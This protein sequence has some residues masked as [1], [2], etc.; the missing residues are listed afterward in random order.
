MVIVDD[1]DDINRRGMASLLAE[2]AAIDVAASLTHAEALDRP[3][4]WDDVDLV[5]VDAAD[6]RNRV[7]HFPG[8]AVVQE[9]GRHRQREQTVIVVDTSSTTL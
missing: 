7:D 8:V 6:E 1:D 2:D 5:L 9:V 4:L 3:S